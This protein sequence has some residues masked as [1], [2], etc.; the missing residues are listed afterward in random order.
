M[1]PLAKGLD[2]LQSDR[3]AYSGVLVP[4]IAILLESMEGLKTKS[5]LQ[6]CKPLIESI[7]NGVNRRF[8]YIFEDARLLMASAAHPMFRLNYIPDCKKSEVTANLKTEVKRCQTQNPDDAMTTEEG[9][10]ETTEDGD[11]VAG[12]VPL[13]R[14]TAVIDEVDTYLNSTETNIAKAFQNLPMMKEIFIKYNTGFPA[15]AACERLFGVGKDIFR[16]KRNRLSDAN[17]EK[18]LLCR[19][20]KHLM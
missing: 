20:N 5:N 12:Y 16:P 9:G 13:L 19:V 18:L 8:E 1:E 4:T 2:L 6:H 10:E 14:P 17:F 11:I 15:S 3:M 7:I